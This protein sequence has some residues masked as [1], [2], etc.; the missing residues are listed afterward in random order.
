MILAFEYKTKQTRV[1]Y[2]TRRR[3]GAF[4]CRLEAGVTGGRD[5]RVPSCVLL[6]IEEM[7]PKLPASDGK[8]VRAL[9]SCI[10]LLLTAGVIRRRNRAASRFAKAT[11]DKCAAALVLHGFS[12][13]SFGFSGS[14]ADDE[15]E[16]DPVAGQGDEGSQDHSADAHFQSD[17]CKDRGGLLP[18][19]RGE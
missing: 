12:L 16:G 2:R 18:I 17:I 1:E 6:T 7:W 8:S 19:I 15:I 13:F 5:A 3:A 4:N 14:V 10:G 9:R 11:Q